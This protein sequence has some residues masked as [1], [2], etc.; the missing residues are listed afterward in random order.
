MSGQVTPPK[1]PGRPRERDP[2][3]NVSSWMRSQEYDKL[4][5]AAKAHDVTVS[6]LV[7]AWLRLQLK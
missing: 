7:R 1:K 3:A 6:A 2:G 4:V 5:K